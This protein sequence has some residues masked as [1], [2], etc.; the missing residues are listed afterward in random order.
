MNMKFILKIKK[1]KNLP[2]GRQ[3]ENYRVRGFTLVE[4]I[5]AVGL[6]ATVS[7]IAVGALFQAQSINAKMQQTHIMLDGINLSIESITRDIRY[8]RQFHCTNH[9]DTEM[10]GNLDIDLTGYRLRNNCLYTPDSGSSGGNTLVLGQSGANAGT[11]DRYIYYLYNGRIM[12][13]EGDHL[14]G[15]STPITSDDVEIEYLKF[16]VSGAES[17]SFDQ[18]LTGVAEVTPEQPV[19]TV[20]IVGVTKPIK[21]GIQKV[22]FK[23]QTTVIPREIDY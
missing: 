7:V 20:V 3:V 5:V 11:N 22:Y 9:S 12:K 23:L 2:V 1:L 17:T 6:F 18:N 8:G 21:I 10:L 16:F 4:L 14:T 13:W 15:T 19:I